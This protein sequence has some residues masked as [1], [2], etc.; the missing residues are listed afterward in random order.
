VRVKVAYDFDAA[1]VRTHSRAYARRSFNKEARDA[2]YSSYT[3]LG[4]PT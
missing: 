1:D 4:T 2:R 3:D